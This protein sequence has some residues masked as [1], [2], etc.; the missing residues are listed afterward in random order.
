MVLP[1]RIELSTSPFITLT[2]CR[3]RLHLLDVGNVL[4]H[5]GR[6]DQI[7]FSEPRF[8]AP[9]IEMAF[10]AI[11]LNATRRAGKSPAIAGLCER[12]E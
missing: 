3:D 12:S 8:K 11:S 9:T 7:F 2:F 10:G 4:V 6:G 1:D 5:R